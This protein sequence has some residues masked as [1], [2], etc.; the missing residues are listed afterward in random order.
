MFFH[1]VL[2]GQLFVDL[3]GSKGKLLPFHTLLECAQS[4]STFLY[5]FGKRGSKNCYFLLKLKINMS[6][7]QLDTRLSQLMNTIKFDQVATWTEVLLTSSPDGHIS[8]KRSPCGRTHIRGHLT[9]WTHIFDQLT[10]F[11]QLTR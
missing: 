5:L 9:R 11:S 2:R 8:S 3:L 7:N 10:L 6:H 1:F 4:N